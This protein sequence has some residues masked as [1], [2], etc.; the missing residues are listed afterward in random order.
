MAHLSDGMYN[1]QGWGAS[2]ASP[3]TPK[4][5]AVTARSRQ[6]DHKET[7]RKPPRAANK[8]SNWKTDYNTDHSGRAA[9]PDYADIWDLGR[10]GTDIEFKEAR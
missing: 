4:L 5:R 3:E 9:T 8:E 7:Q 1:A 6:K 10:L 2:A